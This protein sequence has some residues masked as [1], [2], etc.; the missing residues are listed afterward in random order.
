MNNQ[1]VINQVVITHYPNLLVDLKFP[2]HSKDI[3][4]LYPIRNH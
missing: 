2:K 3:T 4:Y 1:V